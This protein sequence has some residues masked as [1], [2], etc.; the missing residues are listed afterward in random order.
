MRRVP[1]AYVASRHALEG[2]SET[3]RRELMLYGL[4]VIV[5]A[6]GAV[7]T[8]IGTKGEAEDLNTY[9]ATE[10]WTRR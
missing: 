9:V 2:M 3:L 7:V 8:A 1:P 5:I 6:P 4:D 10:I